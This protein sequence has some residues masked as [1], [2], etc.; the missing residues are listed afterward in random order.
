M[1]QGDDFWESYTGERFW[2]YIVGPFIGAALGAAAYAIVYGVE[3]GSESK[4]SKEINQ[5]Q[6]SNKQALLE[7]AV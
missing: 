4:D 2:V 5:E 1:W 7:Q 6:H 3:G